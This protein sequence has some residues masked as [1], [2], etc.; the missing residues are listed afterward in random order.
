[1]SSTPLTLLAAN[2]DENTARPAEGWAPRL[3]GERRAFAPRDVTLGGTWMGMNDAGLVAAVTNR[4]G[5]PR[6]PNRRSRGE[7][8]PGLLAHATVSDAV[9]WLSGLAAL[10]YNGFHALVFDRDRAVVAWPEGDALSLADVTGRRTIVSERSFGAA[11]SLGEAGERPERERWV[12]PAV[13]ALAMGG[14]T[15]LEAWQQLLAEH[16][17]PTFEGLCV[18]WDQHEYGTRSSA[19]VTLAASRVGLVTTDGPPCRSPWAVRDDEVAAALDAR[20]TARPLGRGD[21]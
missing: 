6:D 16:R 3:Y 18:H 4:F 9:A 7:I 17:E 20:S 10:D 12:A 11:R 21:D 15:R 5:L 2:R 14:V 8:V 1:M 19:I 13:A